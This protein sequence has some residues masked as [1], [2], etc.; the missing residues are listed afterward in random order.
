MAN[1]VFA[2]NHYAASAARQSRRVTWRDLVGGLRSP[3]CYVIAAIRRCRALRATAREARAGGL[4]RS[5]WFTRMHGCHL[6]AEY[7]SVLAG[8]TLVPSYKAIAGHDRSHGGSRDGGALATRMPREGGS[9]A[10]AR[11]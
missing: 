5:V 4:E 1:A 11:G 7:L 6:T 3:R 2:S 9:V 10:R 8:M